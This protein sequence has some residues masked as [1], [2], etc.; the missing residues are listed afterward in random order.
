MYLTGSC[1]SRKTFNRRLTELLPRTWTFQ[2]R[3]A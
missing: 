3:G 2:R 1:I